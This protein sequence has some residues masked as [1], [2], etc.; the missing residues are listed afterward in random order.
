VNNPTL[1]DFCLAMLGRADIEES[2]SG[3]AAVAWPPQASYPY[4]NF[5][6]TPYHKRYGDH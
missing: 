4:G 6:V 3:V 5:S 2:K 1:G